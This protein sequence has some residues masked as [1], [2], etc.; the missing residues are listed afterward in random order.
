MMTD[1][2]IILAL[3][4]IAAFFW[5]LRYMAEQSRRFAERECRKQKV[6]LLAIAMES[7]KP[8]LGGHAGLCWQARYQFEFSTDGLNQYR[9]HIVIRG[10][11]ITKIEWPIFPEPLWDE[12]PQARGAVG[13]GCGSRGNCRSGSCR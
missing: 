10:K 2:L 4:V 7:A 11:T 5:Q 13:G 12:A 9:A 6:Q 3:L 1:L 8:S